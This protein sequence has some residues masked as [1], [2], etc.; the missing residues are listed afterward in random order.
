M[1]TKGIDRISPIYHGEGGLLGTTEGGLS[2][3]EL[4]AAMCLQALITNHNSSHPIH[5]SD[6][7]RAVEYADALINELSKGTELSKQEEL[8]RDKKI[9]D[10]PF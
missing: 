2:K 9:G 8:D 4:L 10:L 5:P 7:P 3:R 1:I 6:V